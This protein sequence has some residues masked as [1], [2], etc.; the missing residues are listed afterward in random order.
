MLS[1]VHYGLVGVGGMVGRGV[2]VAVRG[3]PERLRKTKMAPSCHSP[4]PAVTPE[5]AEQPLLGMM[6][7]G[8]AILRGCGQI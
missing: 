4:G 5:R 2:R 1:G 3:S 6:I 8:N 7:E